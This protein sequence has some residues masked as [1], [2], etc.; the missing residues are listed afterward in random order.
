MH[1]EANDAER[2][3]LKLKPVMEELEDQVACNQRVYEA[4]DKALGK[5]ALEHY[6]NLKNWQPEQLRRLADR[7]SRQSCD[8]CLELDGMNRQSGLKQAQTE[9]T[10]RQQLWSCAK[11]HLRHAKGNLRSP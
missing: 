9:P 5:I 1:G 3:Y 4:V 2:L 6:P 7:I 11:Q 10:C 8:F